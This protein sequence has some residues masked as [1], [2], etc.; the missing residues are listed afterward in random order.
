MDDFLFFAVPFAAVAYSVCFWRGAWR[1]AALPPLLLLVVVLIAF[2]SGIPRSNIPSMEVL[3][4]M[5]CLLLAW[6]YLVPLYIA[7]A[8]AWLRAASAE[9]DCDCPAEMDT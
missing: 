8:F 4:A 9:S 7:K 1:R 6:I 2:R 3:V 5:G